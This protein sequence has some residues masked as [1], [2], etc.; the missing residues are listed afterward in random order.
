MK[1]DPQQRERK[2]AESSF[3]LR[4]A[5]KSDAPALIELI[6][7]LARF[8]KLTPPNAAER[9]RLVEG[10]FSARP[11][12]ESWLAFVTGEPKPVAYAIIFETYSSFRARP[13]LYL[14]DIFVL[15]EHRRLGIGSALLRH[16]I[17]LARDRNCARMEWT[18]L[19]WN[20]KAQ[21]VYAGLGARHLKEWYLYRLERTEMKKILGRKP[22]TQR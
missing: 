21:K 2:D 18:C 13:T 5:R 14:E 19:D 20:K 12:F 22:S 3:I 15:P 10:G 4:R 1:R 9:R 16:C 11:R 17:Q 7:A 6:T 8:E